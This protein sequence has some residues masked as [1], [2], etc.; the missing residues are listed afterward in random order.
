MFSDCFYALLSRISLFQISLAAVTDFFLVQ[1][2]DWETVAYLS[3][4]SIYHIVELE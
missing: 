2:L 3:M 4:T 1:Q